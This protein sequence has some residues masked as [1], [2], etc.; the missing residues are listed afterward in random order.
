LDN[1]DGIP[2][3]QQ[4]VHSYNE[5]STLRDS[6]LFEMVDNYSDLDSVRHLILPTGE[7]QIRGLSSKNKLEAITV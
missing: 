5:C 7:E 1:L 4:A 2:F 3:S 6:A